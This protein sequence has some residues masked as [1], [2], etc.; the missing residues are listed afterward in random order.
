MYI[1]W[2]KFYI[3]FPMKI[4]VTLV[5]V[6]FF[7][8]SYA[9]I[10]DFNA[11]MDSGKVEFSKEHYTK[12]AE[13]FEHAV[14]INPGDAEAHYFLGYSY[15]RINSMDGQNMM[16]M[17]L[18]MTIK[19]TGQFEVVNKLAPKYEGEIVLLDPLLK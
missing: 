18:S 5:L 13:Y 2:Q 6:F 19:A 3:E 15:S 1:G 12:S 9:Q 16:D 11:L 4:L 10:Q 17:N 7:T 14:R 8:I